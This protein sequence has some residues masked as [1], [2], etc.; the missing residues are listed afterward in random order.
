MSGQVV[1]VS[2]PGRRT[3]EGGR[4]PCGCR[5][6]RDLAESVSAEGIR[7]SQGHW[8]G[9]AGSSMRVR[10]IHRRRCRDGPWKGCG[11]RAHGHGLSVWQQQHRAGTGLRC[12]GLRPGITVGGSCVGCRRAER[13]GRRGWAGSR[14][15]EVGRLHCRF[16]PYRAPGP[17]ADT[18]SRPVLRQHGEQIASGKFSC[19]GFLHGLQA[20]GRIHAGMHG[21]GRSCTCCGFQVRRRQGLAAGGRQMSGREIVGGGGK[22]FLAGGL[23][24]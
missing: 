8:A 11:A 24:Q 21:S 14:R 15:G 18:G 1:E 20:V 5:G 16:T 2:G 9:G 19:Q 22:G 13:R 6:W 7:S 23:S 4:A 12:G 17:A 10:G 3:G